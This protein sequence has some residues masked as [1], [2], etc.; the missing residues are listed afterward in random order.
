MNEFVNE[1]VKN[2]LPIKTNW[3]VKPRTIQFGDFKYYPCGGIH[4]AKTSEIEVI[5]I[6]NVKKDKGR[7]RIGYD[8]YD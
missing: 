5:V 1:L 6:C 2:D 3:E 8:V 7:L 4:I